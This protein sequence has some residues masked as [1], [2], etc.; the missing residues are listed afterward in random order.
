MNNLNKYTKAE[1]IS[2]VKRLDNNSKN[3]Q[4]I[5]LVELIL[6]FKSWILTLTIITLFV[7]YFKKYTFI[8]KILRFI[9]W[10]ILSIFGISLIDN[11]S[12]SF[13]TNFFYLKSN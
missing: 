5:W 9:N 4:K 2:K 8:N 7:K 13:I 3:N 10:I 12:L 1:L 11:I 6:K